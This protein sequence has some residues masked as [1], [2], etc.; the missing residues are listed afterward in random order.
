MLYH[1]PQ[2][3]NINGRKRN[4]FGLPLCDDDVKK[5]FESTTHMLYC[6]TYKMVCF[7][8]LASLLVR[9]I[10]AISTIFLSLKSLNILYYCVRQMTTISQLSLWDSEI[11]VIATLLENYDS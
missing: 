10:F 6:Y 5:S 1:G 3:K 2:V 7:C 8:L 9:N 11:V 4:I